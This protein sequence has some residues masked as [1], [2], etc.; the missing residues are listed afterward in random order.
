[1]GKLQ[2][3]VN[4]ALTAVGA[5]KKIGE[6]MKKQDEQI[7]LQK[8]TINKLE[9]WQEAIVEE[10]EAIHQD[11]MDRINKPGAKSGEK[12][13]IP[14]D[15]QS[16]P[17]QMGPMPYTPAL[18]GEDGFNLHGPIKNFNVSKEG[19]RNA[20]LMSPPLPPGYY[21]RY[22]P[23][24]PSVFDPASP[25]HTRSR[26]SEHQIAWLKKQDMFSPEAWEEFNQEEARRIQENMD[27]INEPK[28]I[29]EGWPEDPDRQFL[30]Q[31]VNTQRAEDSAFRG[32]RL[33]IEASRAKA[34]QKNSFRNR[35]T[36]YKGGKK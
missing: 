25:F 3:S 20:R 21:G 5:V 10:N 27:A 19:E 32:A 22:V 1:M 9:P 18:F 35:I 11:Q 24:K 31:S 33:S 16:D 2:S 12:V 26:L 17:N 30:S 23:S 4:Q 36:F 29:A 7:A 13:Y 28:R 15:L 8:E 6:H 34:N 14:E